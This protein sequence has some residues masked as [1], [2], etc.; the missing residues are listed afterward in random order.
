MIF[1]KICAL[2]FTYTCVFVRCQI[3]WTWTVVSYHVG[4]EN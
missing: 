1:L 2:M 3:P 4:A